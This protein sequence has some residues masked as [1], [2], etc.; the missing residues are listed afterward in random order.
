LDEKELKPK[1]YHKATKAEQELRIK[2]VVQLKMQGYSRSE[3][4]EYARKKWGIDRAAIDN[5]R[6]IA[7]QKIIEVNEETIVEDIAV[8]TASY[9]QLYRNAYKNIQNDKSSFALSL[10]VG[11]LKEISKIK[12]LEDQVIPRSKT[13]KRKLEDLSDEAIE[14]LYESKK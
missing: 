5:L 1:E 12:G 9:W 10:C 6:A 14:A 7:T 3:I 4:I 2:E 13:M 8:I 11:I